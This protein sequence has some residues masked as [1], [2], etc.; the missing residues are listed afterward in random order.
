MPEGECKNDVKSFIINQVVFHRLSSTFN[1]DPI[2]EIS[3][4]AITDFDPLTVV[5]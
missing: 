5:R 3:T 2:H 1:D 4:T